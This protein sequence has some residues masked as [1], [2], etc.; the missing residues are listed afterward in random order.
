MNGLISN[1]NHHVLP[2]FN[3]S[4]LVEL[5]TKRSLPAG[6]S[7]SSP[8]QQVTSKCPPAN[9]L[10]TSVWRK[11]KQKKQKICQQTN[12]DKKKKNKTER[13]CADREEALPIQDRG[14]TLPNCRKSTKRYFYHSDWGAQQCWCWI[15]IIFRLLSDSFG[16]LDEHKFGN[17]CIGVF[18]CPPVTGLKWP[19]LS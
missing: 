18:V 10:A 17:D 6:H 8:S 19:G 9:H 11:I 4:I 3:F 1:K 2:S 15:V 12:P 5:E 16:V 7:T 13:R 14:A